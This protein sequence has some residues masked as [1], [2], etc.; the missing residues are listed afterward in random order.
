MI[1]A[2]NGVRR[3][4]ASAVRSGA[5]TR[6]EQIATPKPESIWSR[7]MNKDLPLAGDSPGGIPILRF[8]N[9]LGNSNN[10]Y[11]KPSNIPRRDH[12]IAYTGKESCMKLERI[13]TRYAPGSARM[14]MRT[15]PRI[16]LF[17]PNKR[18]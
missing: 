5:P 2:T 10:T 7:M 18:S 13:E 12:E 3:T 4:M 16:V 11:A 6:R 15:N 17:E 14:G 9:E 1:R 8:I